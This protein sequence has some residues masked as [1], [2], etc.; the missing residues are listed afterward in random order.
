MDLFKYREIYLN[1]FTMQKVSTPKPKTQ[2]HWTRDFLGNIV[3]RSPGNHPWV[4]KG[5]AFWTGGQELC[6]GWILKHNP[7]IYRPIFSYKR[8]D[9]INKINK[10]IILQTNVDK[11]WKKAKSRFFEQLC[12]IK[13]IPIFIV[14]QIVDFT[15]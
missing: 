4:N 9:L 1:D 12:L 11:I 2:Y 3:G 5:I 8:N 7:N 13:K 14:M 15:Y 6:I 10:D